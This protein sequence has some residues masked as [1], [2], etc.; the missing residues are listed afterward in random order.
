MR[1]GMLLLLLGCSCAA[2]TYTVTALRPTYMGPEKL[3]VN[4]AT[5]TNGDETGLNK[6]LATVY[7]GGWRIAS[8][9]TADK[10]LFICFER[11]AGTR[12]A[13]AAGHAGR[14]SSRVEAA[15]RQEPS[16]DEA[17]AKAK[18]DEDSSASSP[19]TDTPAPA[20]SPSSD[21][22][23]EAPPEKPKKRHPIDA[24]PGQ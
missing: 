2:P 18:A 6:K 8:S 16:S 3:E 9:G 17:P 13:A 4:C 20:A 23:N 7:G 14:A 1:S 10:D 11:P 22:G 5:F 15:P 12:A 19:A 24:D 21:S